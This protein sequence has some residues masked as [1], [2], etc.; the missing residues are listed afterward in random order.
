MCLHS[1]KLPL[2]PSSCI[3]PAASDS[4]LSV[5]GLP[6]SSRT[7]SS[8]MN[9]T[10]LHTHSSQKH[11]LVDAQFINGLVDA[12]FINGLVDA[13]FINGLVDSQFINGLVDAQFINGLVDAQFI[14][15]PVVTSVQN[16]CNLL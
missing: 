11:N 5:A 6:Q 4:T 14:N 3:Y 10:V 2:G 7:S 8:T 15:G 13:Q 12:Q 16:L 9:Q 1:Y